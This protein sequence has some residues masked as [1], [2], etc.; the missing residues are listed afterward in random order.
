MPDNRKTLIKKR[1]SMKSKLTTFSKYLNVL[2]SCTVLSEMQ[3]AELECRLSKIEDL[4]RDFDTLQDEIE[5]LCEES[6]GECEESSEREQFENDYF[7]LLASARCLLASAK[8][9]DSV[10]S[11]NNSQSG[12]DF[13]ASPNVRLPKIDLPHFSGS[14][15][16]W[17]EFR[18][19]FS[20]IIHNNKNIDNVNKFHYL[21]ASLHGSAALIIKHIT[22]SNDTYN[23]AWD[24]LLE[25]YDNNR[26]LVNNHV[27]ALFNLDQIH[28]ESCKS[29]RYLVDTT[30]KNIRALTT[31]KQP[32]QYW[33]TLIIFMMSSKLDKATLRY[34][35]EHRN[36]LND[37]P[38]LDIFITF[39]RNRADLLESLE[40]HENHSH[41][42][43][44]NHKVKSKYNEN[45]N[46]N[47]SS[48]MQCHMCNQS[49]FLYNCESFKTLSIESRIEKAKQ[50][51]LCLNC[52]RSGHTSNRCNLTG[53]KYCRYKHNTLLH[54]EK[55]NPTSKSNSDGFV[56]TSGTITDSTVSRIFLSTAMVRVI[57][58]H[59][60]EHNA[61]VLLDNGSAINLITQSYCDQ[62]QLP[63][64]CVST[65]VSGFNNHITTSTQSCILTVKSL[66]SDYEVNINCTVFPNIT[67]PIPSSH[68]D[69]SKIRLPLGITLAD[70]TYNTPG[71]ID[72]LLNADI[73][74]DVLGRESI[75]LGTNKPSLRESKLG[76]LITR[77]VTV[78]QQVS[79][80]CMFSQSDSSPDL[81]RFWELDTLDSQ[82][83][84]MSVEEIACEQSFAANTFR[85]DDGRFV[86][87]MPLK[88]DVNVL[89]DSLQLAKIRFFSLE[90]KF[91]R[92]SIFKEK[93]INFMREYETLGHMAENKRF[94]PSP[95]NINY[96]FPHHG[97][98]REASTTTKLR[99]VFDGS[100]ATTSGVSLN[101]L[102]MVGPVVQDDLFSIIIRFRQHKYVVS[103][104]IEKMY[105]AIE[106]NPSQRSLQQ[107]VF[108]YDSSQPL[109]TYTLNTLT[110]GTTSAP[111]LATKCLSSLASTAIDQEVKNA[112]QHDFYIDDFLS[113][114]SSVET[115]IKLAKGVASTLS[116]AKFNIRKWKSNNIDVLKAICSSETFTTHEFT[117]SKVN[118]VSKTLGLN[119]DP[120]LDKFSF[121]INID[122]NQI[123]TKRNILSIISQI[124]DPLG[125]VGACIVEAKIIMQELWVKKFSWDEKLPK[126]INNRW[127]SFVKKLQFLNNLEIPRWIVC[128]DY[129]NTEIHVF[130]DA[131]EDAYGACL[132]IR[133]MNSLGLIHIHLLASK[134]RVA[135]I[136]PVTIPRLELCGALLGARLCVKVKSAL[137]LDI[138]K[139]HFWCDSTVVLG[140]LSSQPNQYK[141]FVSN[142]VNEIQEK[143]LGHTWSYVPSKLN[144]ADFVSRGLSAD[145]LSNSSLWWHGPQFLNLNESMWP[146]MPNTNKTCKLYEEKICLTTNKID[147]IKNNQDKNIIS[148][149]IQKYSNFNKLQRVIAYIQRFINNSQN[150][151][152]S[153]NFTDTFTS[154]ELQKSLYIIIRQAQFEMFPTESLILRAGKA[155]PSNN[156]LLS[157]SPFIDEN[158]IIRVGGRLDNS[159]Y[160]YDVKH[161]ILICSK[162]HVTKLLFRM[163]HLKLL[164]AGP[165][166]L[167]SNIRQSYWPLKGRNLSKLTVNKCLVCFKYKAQTIQPI[168]GQLP[169]NRTN[170]EF[171]F[172]HCCVDYAGPVM[173]ADRKGRGCR[174]LKSYLCIFVCLSVKA[175]HLELVTELTKEAF[176]AALNRFIARRG[177]PQSISSDNGTNFVGASNDLHTFLTSSNIEYD[178]AQEGIEFKFTP[179]YSPHFNGLAEAAV[180]STKHHLRRLLQVVHFT[181]EEMA[182]CLAQIEAI[183]N[184]RPLT[185]LSTDPFEFTAL[186]PSHFLIGRPLTSIP[187][188]HMLERDITC[189]ERYKRIEYIRQ[190]F[191]ARFRNEYI[192]TLQQRT[193]WLTPSNNELKPNDL[194]LIKDKT[195]PPLL[196]PLGRIIKVF[197][198]VDGIN[199]VAEVKTRR[200]NIRRAYNNICPLPAQDS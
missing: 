61:R 170:L 23:I 153:N 121:N 187:H 76:W 21:R 4:N 85:N 94:S 118:G 151:I 175:I 50:F 193:K 146:T 116:A 69:V 114:G 97:V 38:T 25:R 136:K 189:T 155:L 26:L 180:R 35:E 28:K 41:S 92:D 148:N 32:T 99:T 64:R 186:T 40:D 98:I 18:D 162:H 77:H 157:L 63:R 200:G 178:M 124:F 65:A 34:W 43:N 163:Y 80:L 81:S 13:K 198:G 74:W 12:E 2:K 173:I 33:D 112:I 66:C 172:L 156:R 137:T 158:H 161:P 159:P 5:M 89:G 51:K 86:V 87:S 123:A 145:Q 195:L 169:A 47:T 79:N 22:V 106:I 109:K 135:P 55:H 105:R 37:S 3:I 174:L 113:G 14:Y 11:F 150:K 36:K 199:R 101:D 154:L 184:S 197:P 90:R 62:L 56:L 96:Y 185:V 6:P 132:Y 111:Y 58:G 191:W 54:L 188:P 60:K 46:S 120:S 82:N 73:F 134:N 72:I 133:S 45:N 142:R 177:K 100:A 8:R 108:R 119:W 104:D 128:E 67:P 88:R 17:L 143:T 138:K 83:S 48:S 152:K 194:V 147:N 130:T 164:H 59:G 1:S 42:T 16:H 166:L 44:L 127:I 176:I 140:W 139:C 29:I 52:L 192:S 71:N 75:N 126:E 141:H 149:L 39:L 117:D 70:P 95:S 7:A 160:C 27:Q 125:L 122:N 179:P 165:Q 182:T 91:A 181:Y 84:N 115:I 93:Y 131:S 53:C 78:P 20:S 107:I 129:K 31:L 49:H 196:W 24:L 9:R 30:T 183:L 144:P 10:A 19:V 110:Y 167:L 68:I 168:M 57:D 102:Q 15:Q 190:H 171:P 103:G